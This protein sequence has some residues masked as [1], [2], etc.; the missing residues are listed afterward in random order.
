MKLTPS[1]K[2]ADRFSLQG[3]PADC[4]Q[5]VSVKTLAKSKLNTLF[6]L[7]FFNCDTTVGLNDGA[8]N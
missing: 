2:K 6:F 1:K 5:Q 4:K 7:S 3:K 8:L